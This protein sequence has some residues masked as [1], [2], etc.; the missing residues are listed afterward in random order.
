VEIRHLQIG[1]GEI[2]TREIMALEIGA[3]EVAAGA[4]AREPAE[5]IGA[6]VGVGGDRI[7]GQNSDETANSE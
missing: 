7:E 2:G 5:K 4:V 1:A 3:R 6:R